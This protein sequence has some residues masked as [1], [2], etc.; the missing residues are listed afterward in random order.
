MLIIFEGEP[1]VEMSAAEHEATVGS[2]IAT[3][4]F[5]Q[6]VSGVA[7][8]EKTASGNLRV[9]EMNKGYAFNYRF[10]ECVFVRMCMLVCTKSDVS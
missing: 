3:G 4:S 7:S 10:Y 2:V 1:L 6:L 5:W 9:I 8:A